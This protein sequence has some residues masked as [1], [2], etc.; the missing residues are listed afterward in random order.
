MNIYP[1][2]KVELHVVY[3][4][5]FTKKECQIPRS[6]T[7]DILFNFPNP[8]KSVLMWKM[9]SWWSQA[10][11]IRFFHLINY[12]LVNNAYQTWLVSSFNARG[13]RCKIQ[14]WLHFTAL[15]VGFFRD[16]YSHNI[17]D[18]QCFRPEHH[19]RDIND[20][21]AH[22]VHQNCYRLNFT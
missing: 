4:F 3:S 13:N 6:E 8:Q 16:L 19:W 10:H 2:Y 7:Q 1:S 15:C 21:N 12:G 20:W 18:F 14:I 17:S 11:H 9:S 22:L 5:V